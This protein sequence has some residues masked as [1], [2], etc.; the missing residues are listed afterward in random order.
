MRS[1]TLTSVA[2][3][4][5]CACASTTPT[6]PNAVGVDLS[7]FK[8]GD[9]VKIDLAS[10]GVHT[11]TYEGDDAHG[12]R[13]VAASGTLWVDRL[14]NQHRGQKTGGSAKT[15]HDWIRI[16]PE[17]SDTHT[18]RADGVTRRVT[19]SASA[20]QGTTFTV[21]C[22]DKRS[23]KTLAMIRTFVLDA[24]TRMF[25]HR[26]HRNEATGATKTLRVVGYEAD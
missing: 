4:F 12:R 22:R 5:L 24:E 7:G 16:G 18:Y 26:E 3:L 23:D 6:P 9:K 17:E 10:E 21:T 2:A 25:H 19:C 8:L 20:V 14:G 13:L 15:L 11:F 1:I